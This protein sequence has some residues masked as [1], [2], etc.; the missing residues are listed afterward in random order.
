MDFANFLLSTIKANGW[1]TGESEKH[2]NSLSDSCLTKLE[3]C[4]IKLKSIGALNESTY[5]D[6]EIKKLNKKRMLQKY[7]LFA[8]IAVLAL[9]FFILY[10]FGV[11]E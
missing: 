10:Q 11:L 8:G 6:N 2:I 7:M 1:K 3:Q 9:I 4:S 5:L